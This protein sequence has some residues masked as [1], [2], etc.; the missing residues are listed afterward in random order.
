MSV[1]DGKD[2]FDWEVSFDYT[3]SLYDL[4][5]RFA[6]WDILRCGSLR[7]LSCATITTSD[8]A[9]PSHLP[10]WAPD[11]TQT[12]STNLLVR[13]NGRT[14]FRASGSL[15][16]DIWFTNN[17]TLLHAKGSMIG[18]VQ[19]IGSRPCLIKSTSL[20][21]IDK[22]TVRQLR[23]MREWVLECW[24]IAAAGQPMTPAIYE[25]FWV[26]MVCGLTASA[27]PV[28]SVYS[29]YFLGYMRF[30]RE[31]PEVLDRYL[32]DE[33]PVQPIP[34]M[35][36]ALPFV[37]SHSRQLHRWFN[38][39]HNFNVL[40]EDSLHTWSLNRR[41]CRTDNGRL[42]RIP[43]HAKVGDIICILYGSQVPYVLR[44]Q[45]DETYK[46]IGE[47]YVH[48]MMHGKGL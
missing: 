25:A 8:T 39:S 24:R 41:F 21:E 45:G 1:A 29:K 19:T 26:T 48:G 16:K 7:S 36:L 22:T 23:S 47:C 4:L 42:A 27:H 12:R 20:F 18:Q 5:R 15:A 33:R 13:W 32:Q 6:I 37:N 10:S 17:T 30:L 28:P 43:D 46:V 35:L 14:G 3:L 44:K 11:W 31:A 34:P 40:I 2:I 38:Q 9:L